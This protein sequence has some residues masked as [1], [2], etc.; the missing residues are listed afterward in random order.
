MATEHETRTVHRAH[1]QVAPLGVVLRASCPA[2]PEAL[3]LSSGVALVGSG[4][5]CNLVLDDPTVSRTHV[6]LRL[7][8][9]GLEVHDLQ[10]RN[11][12]MYLGQRI[13]RAILAPGTRIQLGKATLAIDLDVDALSKEPPP[14]STSFR[15][16]V[17]ASAQM[18]QL[19]TTIS[20]LDGSLVSV[21]VHGESGVGK[22]LVARAIHEGC[23]LYTSPSPRD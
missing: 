2:T 3:V 9:E 1:V 22:E 12:T 17:G 20:R 13:T 6:E 23:L 21:L 15:G 8:P 14:R 5:R 7:V 16:M 18:Q 11:G 10:S 4:S 19:F